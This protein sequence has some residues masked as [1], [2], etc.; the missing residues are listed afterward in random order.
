[1]G[2]LGQDDKRIAVVLEYVVSIWGERNLPLPKGAWVGFHEFEMPAGG[3]SGLAVPTVEMPTQKM[4]ADG[5]PE[6]W[7]CKGGPVG[8]LVRQEDHVGRCGRLGGARG[9]LVRAR[10]LIRVRRERARC[11]ADDG[12]NGAEGLECISRKA[13]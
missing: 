1:M 9:G 2:A 8:C 3:V 11:V 5:R 10:Q 12:G 13:G 6:I 7:L 4:D